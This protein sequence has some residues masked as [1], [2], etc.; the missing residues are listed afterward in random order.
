MVILKAN[1][2]TETWWWNKD[3]NMAVCRKRWLF[4]ISK[5]SQLVR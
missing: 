1:P 5:Q 4:R 2:G 3:V